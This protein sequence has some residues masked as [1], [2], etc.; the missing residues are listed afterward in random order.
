MN[1]RDLLKLFGIGT[2]GTAVVPALH[3]HTDVNMP[4]PAPAPAPVPMLSDK[5]HVYIGLDCSLMTNMVDLSI[6]SP[7]VTESGHWVIWSQ[8]WIPANLFEANRADL[9]AY[10]QCD[11]LKVVDGYVVSPATIADT[12]LR[13]ADLSDVRYVCYDAW[14]ASAIVELLRE[15]LV[16]AGYRS[17]FGGKS[18]LAHI[19]QTQR[20]LAAPTQRLLGLYASGRINI[21]NALAREQMRRAVLGI[22]KNVGIAGGTTFERPAKRLEEKINSRTGFAYATVNAMAMCPEEGQG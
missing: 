4:A 3:G 19:P 1:R 10:E 12:I 16:P 6:V 22:R 11:A 13:I 14:N 18:V 15:K 2:V 8:H 7:P 5:P 21:L 9:S 17:E 20:C